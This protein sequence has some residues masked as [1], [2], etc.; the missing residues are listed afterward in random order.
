VIKSLKCPTRSLDAGGRDPPRCPP[1]SPW[2]RRRRPK[3]ACLSGLPCRGL[4][5]SGQDPL[6]WPAAFAEV[7]TSAA[8][9]RRGAPPPSPWSRRQRPKTASLACLPRRGLDAGGRD[10]PRC[11][12]F[13]AAVLTPAA[14]AGR[15][16]PRF[17]VSLAVV[18]TPAA[19]MR[20]S[21][22]PP[23]P[24][25]RR[26]RPKT[27]T[28]ACLP[29]SGLDAVDRDAPLWPAFLAAVTARSR[30]R[31]PKNAAFAH[32]PRSGLDA[33]GQRLPLLPASPAAVARCFDAGG[34][35]PPRCPAALAACLFF[36]A[37]F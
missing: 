19:K 10:P 13:L 16:A 2:S 1:P 34:R 26:R 6:W 3:T 8:E 25:S 7:S 31:R 30:R 20:R 4:D 5:A 22:P 12:A 18:S 24:W 28:L 36:L 15:Y 23:S 11:P 21:A 17:P 37:N 35:G 33:G 32:L 29:R 27:A 9:M 14:V